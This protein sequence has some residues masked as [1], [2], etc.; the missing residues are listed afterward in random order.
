MGH[1]SPAMGGLLDLR[2]PWA[3]LTGQSLEPGYLGRLGPIT[4]TQ[5]SYLA[6]LAARDPAARWQVIVTDSG[7][8]TLAVTHVAGKAQPQPQ[9]GLVGQ[10]TVIIGGE[11]LAEPQDMAGLPPILARVL[12]AAQSA[13]ALAADNSQGPGGCAHAEATQAYRPTRKLWEHVT[14]RDLTCRFLT[15]RQ[16][17]T[18]CDLDHTI[19]FDQGGRTCS[20]NLGGLCRFHHQV[21]GQSRWFL[22]QATPGTFTWITPTGRTYT[23]QPDSHAA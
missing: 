14:A 21:K 19:P 18:R 7:G 20:C 3:T 8:Q 13:A 10:I 5:A 2:L 11:H 15:C 23:T 9:V 6:D 16:P 22:T 12:A 17:A 1:V 4:A